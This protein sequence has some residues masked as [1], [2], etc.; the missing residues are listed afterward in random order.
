MLLY[1]FRPFFFL[2]A[3][4]A[5]IA[6]AV[7]LLELTGIGGL[8]SIF[9]GLE[10]HM[11]EMLFGFAVAAA[12]G[13]L[14][15]AIPSW[16]GRPPVRGILLSLLVLLWLAGRIAVAFS[17]WIGGVAAAVID[18][19]FLAA[20][21]AVVSREI[22]A[23]GNWRNLPMVVALLTLLMANGLMHAEALGDLET[24]GSGWR[25]AVATLTV[26]ITLIGGRIVPNFIRNWLVKRPAGPLPAPFGLFDRFTLVA[27]V[28]AFAIWLILPGGDAACVA[29]AVAAG[30]NFIRL[31]RWQ[32]HRTFAD[33]LLLVLHVGWAWVPIGLALLAVAQRAETMVSE[34]TAVH[35][36]AVGA[37]GTMILAVMTRATLGHTGRMLAAGPS[38]VTVY[39]LVTIAALARVAAGIWPEAGLLLWVAG[40]AWMAAFGGFLGVYGPMLL[41]PRLDG[42]PG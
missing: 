42:R 22:V 6:L 23:G 40:G 25:L 2:S 11:H 15:T 21:A 31:V 33:P 36:L 28:V 14:L 38:T 13:F 19:A 41:R 39:V 5:V 35:A 1:G 32:G 30:L 24:S 20:L 17:G 7:W 4:S 10:W 27:T 26:L 12:A 8:E 16:T 18:L 34:S 29:L 9:L 37:F 3:L